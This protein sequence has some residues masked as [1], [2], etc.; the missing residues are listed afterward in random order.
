MRVPVKSP[1]E[2][3]DEFFNDNVSNRNSLL[4]CQ[5]VDDQVAKTIEKYSSKIHDYEISSFM[6]W[7]MPHGF[8]IVASLFVLP[9]SWLIYYNKK[10]QHDSFTAFFV[11]IFVSFIISVANLYAQSPTD[12]SRAKDAALKIYGFMQNLKI[13]AKGENAI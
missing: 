12:L 13:G 11:L 3:A 1:R 6:P 5:K 8:G 2:E 7:F 4:A 10:E 9:V